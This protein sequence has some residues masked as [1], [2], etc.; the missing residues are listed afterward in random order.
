MQ[1]WQKDILELLHGLVDE[2]E[3][4]FV[5]MNEMVDIFFEFAQEFDEPIETTET[6]EIDVQIES[7][8]DD[9]N[10]PY[11]QTE[12]MLIEDFDSGFPFAV[13]AN[14]EK[15]PA[16]IGCRHYHGYAYGG[17]LLVCGMHPEGWKD[18]NCPDWEA[19]NVFE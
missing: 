19:E 5:D 12:G 3:S 6:S 8:L 14:S 13:D 7:F 11:W 4:F 15:N 9:F 1:K 2:V 17:N 16:C 18:R 10:D